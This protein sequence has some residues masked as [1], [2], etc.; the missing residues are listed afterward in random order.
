MK[1]QT[2]FLLGFLMWLPIAAIAG[3]NPVFKWLNPEIIFCLS[4]DDETLLPDLSLGAVEPLSITGKASFVDG[5][6]GKA[7]LLGGDGGIQVKYHSACN[8]DLTRP[9]A[10]S[11]WMAP[12]DWLQP[13]E[14]V[15]ERPYLRFFHLQ[16]A[17]AGYFFI[18]R[19]GFVNK[20]LPNGKLSKRSDMF[21]AGMYSFADWKNQL[22]GAYDTLNWQ[23]GEWRFFVIN[24][25]RNGMS[26]HVNSKLKNQTRYS[27]VLDEKDFPDKKS[28]SA[29]FRIG[30][31]KSRETTRLDD[32]IV[33]RRNLNEEEI[34]KLYQA[35]VPA[36]E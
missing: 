22:L 2:M 34:R 31:G 4:F 7:L 3:E 36:G 27:R 5:I 24:W 9:G 21:Q 28:P 35:G 13:G 23:N 19:Q 12:E 17:G 29:F 33:Y 30:T 10:L 14:E 1:D 26:L 6:Y 8:V 32:L 18:Q 15:K 16:G 20:T 11:F 25:D